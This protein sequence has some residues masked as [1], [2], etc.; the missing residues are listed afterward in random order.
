M[1][2]NKHTWLTNEKNLAWKDLVQVKL[3]MD[4]EGFFREN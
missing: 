2:V 4:F 3:F 1:F